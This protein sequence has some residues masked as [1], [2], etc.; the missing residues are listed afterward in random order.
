MARVLVIEPDEGLR[1]AVE[2]ELRRE[3]HRPRWVADDGEALA[4]FDRGTPDAVIL[5]L[6]SQ[7]MDAPGLMRQ[8]LARDPRLPL[9]IF[10]DD[11]A[12]QDDPQ[13]WAADAF[14]LKHAEPSHLARAV[15][16]TLE[17]RWGS[18]ADSVL[19]L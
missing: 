17:A 6:A 5:D 19:P 18:L 11:P 12:R 7:Q 13:A 15:R 8:I 9:V 16:D 14:V 4:E 1:P 3:G 10:T 2:A